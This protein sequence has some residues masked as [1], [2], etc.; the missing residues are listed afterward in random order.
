MSKQISILSIDGRGV[1]QHLDLKGFREMGFRA[2]ALH[3][4]ASA[5]ALLR[6][7]D[8]QEAVEI[9]AA[10]AIKES[11]N[12]I[13]INL[14]TD[15]VDALHLMHQFRR[16][17]STADIL[18]VATSVQTEGL[19]EERVLQAG[20]DLFV[21]QPLPRQ[22][23]IKQIRG[24][25]RQQSRVDERVKIAGRAEFIWEN[26]R[27]QCGI[28]NI[29]RSGVLLATR[30][31]FEKGT[32]VSINIF[33]ANARQPLIVEGEFVRVSTQKDKGIGVKFTSLSSEQVTTLERFIAQHSSEALE[34]V[35]Y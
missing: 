11:I 26:T 22:N 29:S 5:Q 9:I 6:A 15:L 4:H 18:L 21:L 27:Y 24:L 28:A 33:L 14:D 13:I 20:A 34:M 19:L 10:L 1:A 12:L 3:S 30:I 2:E 16:R 23:F 31:N 7:A 35:Y 32:V 8:K 25:L 17:T